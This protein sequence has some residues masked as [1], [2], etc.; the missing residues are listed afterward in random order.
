MHSSDY[1]R[2]NNANNFHDQQS[3]HFEILKE[4]KDDETLLVKIET[5]L[6]SSEI[7][8]ESVLRPS[9]VS[10]NE[11]TRSNE[12]DVVGKRRR[13]KEYFQVEVISE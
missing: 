4:E 5:Q 6:T 7:V 13:K 10:A 11:L 3:S 2:G 8:G 1:S 12:D 9:S